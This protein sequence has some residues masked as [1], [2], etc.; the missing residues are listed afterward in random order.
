MYRVL[1]L[2]KRIYKMQ[3]VFETHGLQIVGSSLYP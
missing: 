3:K 2:K 1:G